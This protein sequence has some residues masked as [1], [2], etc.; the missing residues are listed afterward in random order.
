MPAELTQYADDLH[1]LSQ[2]YRQ[3]AR[4]LELAARPDFAVDGIGMPIRSIE[5]LRVFL[6]KLRIELIR[7]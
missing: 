2:Q 7:R 5:T 1:S 6:G 4:E 3:V